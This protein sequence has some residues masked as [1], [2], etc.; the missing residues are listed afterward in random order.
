MK[1]ERSLP[2]W[3]WAI[4]VIIGITIFIVVYTASLGTLK[5]IDKPNLPDALKDSKEEAN[6]RHAALKAELDKMI[7]LRKKMERRVAIIYTFVRL[8]LVGLWVGLM[9]TLYYYEFIKN[10][11]DFLN[12]SE[13]SLIVLLA[14]NFITFGNITNLNDFL[15]SVRIRVENIVW[16]TKITLSKDI[17]KTQDELANQLTLFEKNVTTVQE[18]KLD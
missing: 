10:V 12:Y 6:K 17:M 13:A 14:F 1:K 5:S 8:I 11:G 2:W 9:Y 3:V 18:S 16:S 15:S 4:I 7:A